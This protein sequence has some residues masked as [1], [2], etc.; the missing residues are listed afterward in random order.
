MCKHEEKNC[1]RC[2]SSFECKVGDIANCQCNTIK[3][4]DKERDYIAAQFSDCLCA[5]CMAAMKTAYHQLQQQ[6]QLNIF[7]KG[8]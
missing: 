8:R 4:S 6:L 2:N 3:L 7:L 5:A 1:P